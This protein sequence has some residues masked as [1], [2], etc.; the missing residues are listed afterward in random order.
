MNMAWES[1]LNFDYCMTEHRGLTVNNK[2]GQ[3]FFKIA[4]NNE[5]Q[6]IKWY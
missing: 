6:V 3:Y 2:L 1:Y 4:K 5:V